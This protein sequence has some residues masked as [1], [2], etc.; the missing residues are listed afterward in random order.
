MGKEE[1]LTGLTTTTSTMTRIIQSPFDEV[2]EFKD[3]LFHFNFQ[4]SLKWMEKQGRI[5]FGDHFRIYPED[6]VLIYKLLVYAINDQESCTKSGLSL[7]KGILLIGPVGAGKS[8]LMSLVNYFF[9]PEKQYR[10]KAAREI[11]FEL[12]KDGYSVFNRYSKGSVRNLNGRIIPQVWCFDDLGVDNIQKY[13]G[14][15]CNVMAEILLNRY[16]QFVSRGVLTHATTNL[17]APELEE[18][19]G[20]RI[21]SR[22]REMFNLVAFDKDA[23][24]KRC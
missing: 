16:D 15:Q 24:D 23:K 4:L 2:A 9:P 17:S 21:R 18:R 14:T 5:L 1:K 20:N 19:Y 6:H 7:R 3:G 22:M 13:F 11:S 10:I 8:Q 12:E